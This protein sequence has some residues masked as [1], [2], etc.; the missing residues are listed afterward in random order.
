MVYRTLGDVDKALETVDPADAARVLKTIETFAVECSITKV[1]T[2]EALAFAVDEAVQVFG[3]NGYSREF[4]VERAYRD[5]RITR[6][7]EGTNEI[8]RL[9]IPT[10]LLK[11]AGPLL[12]PPAAA[13]AIGSAFALG[14]YGATGVL[15]AEHQ[16]LADVKRLARTVLTALAQ[17]FGAAVRDQQEVLAHAADIVI[18]CYAIESA[19]ARAGKMTAGR[20]ER[21]AIAIDIARVYASDALDRVGH[22]GRQIVNALAG[23]G[24]PIDRLTAALARAREHPGVDTISARRRIGDAAI[25]R[26]RYPFE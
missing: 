4:P 25:D 23:Q 24:C 9:I 3:G 20:G 6:I 1:A 7:Y 11:H 18:E 5:A 15:E 12:T 8:N 21:A 10:R 26:Q 22:A 2:S 14:S 19:L 17:V 16:A 13:N